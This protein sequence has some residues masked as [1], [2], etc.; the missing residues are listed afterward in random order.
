MNNDFFL[1]HKDIVPDFYQAVL[2]AREEIEGQ[3]KPVSEVCRVYGISRSTYYKYKD[4]IFNVGDDTG[5]KAIMA[6]RA[7]NVKGVLSTLLNRI[8]EAS[9]NV[10]TINQDMPVRNLAHFTI[11]I[12][13]KDMNIGLKELISILNAEPHIKNVEL[14]AFE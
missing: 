8:A 12:D 14:I 4:K 13:T 5:K 11:V 1:V 7:E 9:A 3:S 6:F 10:L 2:K